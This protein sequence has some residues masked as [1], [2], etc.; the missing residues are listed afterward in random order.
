MVAREKLTWDQLFGNGVVVDIDIHVWRARTSIKPAD[1]GIPDSV[2]VHKALALGCLRLV[3]KDA[4]DRIKELVAQAKRTL[5][6]YSM[7][8]P[9]VYGVRYVPTKSQKVLFEN[10]KDIQNKINEAADEFSFAD[11]ATAKNEQL[12]IIRKA[13]Q[14]ATGNTEQAAA[15]YDRVAAEYPSPE[16]VRKKFGLTW[17][18]FTISGS[19]SADASS[20]AQEE[21]ENV[22]GVVREMITQLRGE[23]TDKLGAV[24]AAVARGGK[25]PQPS[26]DSAIEVMDRI[27]AMNVFGD[28]EL[29]NQVSILRRILKSAT[30]DGTTKSERIGMVSDLSTMA[31]TMDKTVEQ[32]VAEAE[33]S[34]TSLGRRKLSL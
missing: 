9:F 7:S 30:D 22:K 27:D 34:L 29:T 4:L 12:P 6:Y 3:P 23:F 32:A 28:G 15:A 5:E 33:K 13:L 11:Y 25:I 1:L 31:K 10:L 20:G 18:V 16:D 21:T 14:D 8:F 2:E 26:V 24:M 17:R 19:K